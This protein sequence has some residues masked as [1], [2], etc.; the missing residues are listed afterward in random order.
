M[1]IDL[2]NVSYASPCTTVLLVFSEIY[3]SKAFML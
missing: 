1:L 2:E 3:Q